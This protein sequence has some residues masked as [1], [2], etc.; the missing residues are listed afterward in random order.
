MDKKEANALIRRAEEEIAH[1]LKRLEY[2]TNQYVGEIDLRKQNMATH[3]DEVPQY[4]RHV[5]LVMCH[6]PGSNWR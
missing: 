6:P 4:I 5:A 1:I 3:V 2:E